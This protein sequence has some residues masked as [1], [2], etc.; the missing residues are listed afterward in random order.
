MVIPQS[1]LQLLSPVLVLLWPLAIVFPVS[2]SA[3]VYCIVT[4]HPLLDILQ[5]LAGLDDALDLVN[6]RRADAHYMH[7]D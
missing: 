7:L 3:H 4:S 2:S 1:D 6:H 5:D